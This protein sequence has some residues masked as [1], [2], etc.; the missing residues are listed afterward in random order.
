V[1]R[2][3]HERKAEDMLYFEDFK[4]GDKYVTRARTI[5]EADIVNFA[6][7]SGDWHPLH[8]DA[9]YAAKA[10]FGERIA[11]GMLVLSVASGLLPLYDW[12]IIAF[13]GIDRLRFLAPTKIGDTL[14]VE[15][16]ITDCRAKEIGGVVVFS[17]VAI[18]QR[19][20]AVCKADVKVFVRLREEAGQPTLPGPTGPSS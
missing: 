17:Q 19:D 3:T 4:V 7:F 15:L 6:G 20:E 2:A 12:A 16:E 18:N 9:E 14:H 13:Y 5:T 8:V 10:I 11:H 1:N